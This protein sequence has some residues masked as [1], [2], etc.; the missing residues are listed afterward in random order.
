MKNIIDILNAEI[1]KSYKYLEK[2]DEPSQEQTPEFEDG[3]K[4]GLEQAR[5]MIQDADTAKIIK[6]AIRK[7]VKDN[8]GASEAAAPSW[9]IQEL[10]NAINTAIKG[11]KL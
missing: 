7:F 5:R 10:T 4:S 8:Y 1:K 6:T 9:N 11:G 2:M 3:Y